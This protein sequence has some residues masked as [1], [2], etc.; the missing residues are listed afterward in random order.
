MN[1]HYFCI[2]NQPIFS[3]IETFL[4]VPLIAKINFP[5]GRIGLSEDDL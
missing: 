1:N 4:Q 3:G 2:I 5:R